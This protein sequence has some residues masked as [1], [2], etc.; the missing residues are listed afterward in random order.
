M[1]LQ[2]GVHRQNLYSK[3]FFRNYFKFQTTQV[4]NS[5]L[6]RVIEI[7]YPLLIPTLIH[8]LIGFNSSAIFSRN[9]I[10]SN[11]LNQSSLT[12]RTHLNHHFISNF[13]YTNNPFLKLEFF[14]KGNKNSIIQSP[15]RYF[16]CIT[17][18]LKRSI[19]K[20]VRMCYVLSKNFR[21]QLLRR[22]KSRK[23][24]LKNKG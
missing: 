24:F 7:N 15:K 13:I 14:I 20:N 19:L 8:D 1:Q 21:Y 2:E 23:Y 9:N 16:S 5:C 22:R 11:I 6:G 12:C 3:K 10:N 4:E 18:S 17:Q